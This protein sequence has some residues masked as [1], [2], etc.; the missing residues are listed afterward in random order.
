MDRPALHSLADVPGLETDPVGGA[1]LH[2]GGLA[3][4]VHL[5][6]D[7][8]DARVR[9]KV[10][11]GARVAEGAAAVAVAVALG[12]GCVR[13]LGAGGCGGELPAP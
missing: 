13:L 3:H 4:P 9:L 5:G 7:G 6:V 10:G 2:L 8:V 11:E 1:A 12:H